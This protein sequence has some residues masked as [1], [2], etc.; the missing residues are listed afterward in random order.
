V[1]AW[2][3]VDASRLPARAEADRQAWRKQADEVQA[4]VLKA[5]QQKYEAALQAQTEEQKRHQ[6]RLLVER[7]KALIK[8]NES[9]HKAQELR[10]R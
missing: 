3:W 10:K 2:W 6:H 9:R 1:L 5:E 8:A 4:E 7:K